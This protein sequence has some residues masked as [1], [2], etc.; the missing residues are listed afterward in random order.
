MDV[1]LW[2]ICVVITGLGFI[3]ILQLIKNQND[4]SWLDN[5]SFDDDDIFLEDDNADAFTDQTGDRKH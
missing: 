4:Q 2:I 5:Y 3:G 1:V